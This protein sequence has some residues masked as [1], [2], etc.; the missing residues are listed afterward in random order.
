M[1][2]NE[3]RPISTSSVHA[4]ASSSAASPE[5][6]S[7][8]GLVRKSS[9]QPYPLRAPPAAAAFSPQTEIVK[10]DF[11]LT[12]RQRGR[13]G[14]LVC[15]PCIITHYRAITISFFFFSPPPCSLIPA[16]HLANQSFLAHLIPLSRQNRLVQPALWPAL[17]E[18]LSS[19][20]I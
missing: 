12:Q 7:H 8:N 14:P 9:A 1:V 16:I 2:L 5:S 13:C 19:E 4:A 10:S 18:K 11:I 17:F 3:P 6:Q 20:T 15:W